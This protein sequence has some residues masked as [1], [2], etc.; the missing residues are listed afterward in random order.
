MKIP[1]RVA[2]L[3]PVI[4]LIASYFAE[5]VERL[6][7]GW[8]EFLSSWFANT[9]AVVLFMMLCGVVILLTH[10]FF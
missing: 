2:V 4:S 1:G 8:V 6:W 10:K 5:A 3:I 9:I 7:R